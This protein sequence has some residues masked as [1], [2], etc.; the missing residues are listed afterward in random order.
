MKIEIEALHP[1][2]G[3]LV[4]VK[5]PEDHIL[6]LN[7]NERQILLGKV[8]ATTKDALQKAG[9]E[10]M[11]LVMAS[12]FDLHTIGADQMAKL[13]WQRVPEPT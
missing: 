2:P 7:P 11:V 5:V 3:D 13:G 1:Q 10:N 6:A 9:H 4:V 8:L 12:S